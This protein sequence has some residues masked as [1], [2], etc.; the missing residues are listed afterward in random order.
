MCGADN[1]PAHSQP[2]EELQPNCSLPVEPK[3][4]E[5]NAW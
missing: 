4:V 1:D 5:I 3:N 2:E